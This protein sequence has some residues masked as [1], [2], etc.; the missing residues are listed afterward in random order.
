M[1]KIHFYHKKLYLVHHLR[2][3]TICINV[4]EIRESCKHLHGFKVIVYQ[5][6][7]FFKAERP[8]MCP[9]P[10]KQVGDITWESG[11]IEASCALK[12]V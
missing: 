3:A 12:V 10:A 5:K 8:G 7:D 9:A 4:L 6:H 1:I 11:A 2:R